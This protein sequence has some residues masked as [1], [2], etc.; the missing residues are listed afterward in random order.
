MQLRWRKD[1]FEQ[2]V[3]VRIH[4]DDGARSHAV[5]FCQPPRTVHQ[6]APGPVGRSRK[7]ARP[8]GC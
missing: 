4:L 6:W 8:L 2:G 7:G 5:V 3:A 1:S